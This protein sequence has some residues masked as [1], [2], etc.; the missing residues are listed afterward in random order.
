MA[1]PLI[2]DMAIH[3]FDLMRFFLESDPVSIFG[4]SWNPPWSWYKGD[5]AAA[6][7]LEFTNGVVVAYNGSWC[8]TGQET[9]W[10]AT[11][12]FEGEH[13]VAWLE[14]DQVYLQLKQSELENMGSYQRHQY[15]EAVL[16][17]PVT[18]EYLA[19]AYLLHEFYLAV[20]KGA[21]PATLCQDNIKSLAIVFDSIKS[22][23]AGQPVRFGESLI[24]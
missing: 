20:L 13:G 4:R 21:T 15:Q 17:E 19:Q 18:L 10:N 22:F 8:A 16:V 6:L 12:R 23:E 11:W 9:T 1:Y 7:M 3:H 24:L 14:D 2:I 5:A